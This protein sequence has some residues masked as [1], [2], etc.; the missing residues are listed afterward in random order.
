ML[1]TFNSGERTEKEWSNLLGS[2]GL[3]IEKVWN[4]GLDS[5]C[6]IEARKT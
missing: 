6:V 3:K 5:E 1:L 4:G 2:V